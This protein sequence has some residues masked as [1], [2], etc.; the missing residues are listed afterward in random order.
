[1]DRDDPR[2]STQNSLFIQAPRDALYRA[3][4]DREALVAWQVPGEMTAEVHAF[5]ARPGGG[6][7]MSLFYPSSEEGTSGKSAEREDRYRA[8][9]V[10]LSPDRI[11]EA[12][13]FETDD[14]AFTGEMTM[15]ITLA[16]RDG[17]T[18]VTIRFE[19]IPPGIAP[20]D[21]EAGTNS[22]LEKLARFVEDARF[23]SD[24]AD[25]P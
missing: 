15:V 8:R 18:D 25:S 6:Y 20:A 3:F 14:P 12:I 16:E 10:E 13:T 24:P 19:N 22:S 9:F 21:N 5:D 17:G 4:T 1:M 7:R 11:V 23:V 2:A